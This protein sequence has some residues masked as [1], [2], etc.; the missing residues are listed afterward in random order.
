[1]LEAAK[2][3][4]HRFLNACLITVL[5]GMS[6]VMYV[7]AHG[8]EGT[9]I[10][11]CVSNRNGAVRIVGAN[12]GCD[13][14][15][16]TALDWSIQGP[17]GDTGDTGPMGPQGEPGSSGLPAAFQTTPTS[18]DISTQFPAYTLISTVT[19]PPGKYFVSATAHASLSTGLDSEGF[20]TSPNA[21]CRLTPT[22]GYTVVAS[23]SGGNG[24]GSIS[25]FGMGIP[26]T[27]Q[28]IVASPAEPVTVNLECSSSDLVAPIGINN[29]SLYA[30]QV[31]P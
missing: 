10:H 14:N 25:L 3:K 24:A 5:L 9:L 22:D 18:A 7:S 4:F 31:A 28:G 15:R 19:L 6:G 16:E 17:K 8:G 12:T 11:A 30:I 23:G 26:F 2:L 1:M 27:I 20:V 29:A 13:A 21:L